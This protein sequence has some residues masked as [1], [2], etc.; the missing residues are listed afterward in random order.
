MGDLRRH[1]DRHIE[2]DTQTNTEIH[3]DTRTVRKIQK[4][5]TRY[6]QE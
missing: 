4:P 1:T 2:A 5:A 6:Q 3:E